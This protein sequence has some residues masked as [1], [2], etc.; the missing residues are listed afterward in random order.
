MGVKTTPT[1]KSIPA[2]HYITPILHTN[3]GKENNILEIFIKDMQAFS[4]S[5]TDEYVASQRDIETTSISLRASKELIEN[6]LLYH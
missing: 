4:R 1:F 6:F 5:Y 3:I 2:S